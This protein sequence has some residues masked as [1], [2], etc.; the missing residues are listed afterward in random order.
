MLGRLFTIAMIAA[1]AYW[2]WT[3]PYQERV[4]P[5]Y[6]QK[7]RKNAEDMRLCIRSGNYQLGATGVGDGNVEHPRFDLGGRNGHRFHSGRTEPIDGHGR[8]F[9]RQ[10]RGGNG[11]AG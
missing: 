2:Y 11:D 8:D 7:L 10:A 5:N 9:V 4:N 3:G 1:A 6:E